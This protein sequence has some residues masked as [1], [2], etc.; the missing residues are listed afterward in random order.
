MHPQLYSFS[1]LPV[2]PHCSCCARDADFQA[3]VFSHIGDGKRLMLMI[4][5]AFR[6]YSLVLAT[7]DAAEAHDAGPAD[8]VFKCIGRRWEALMMQLMLM[9]LPFRPG[10]LALGQQE[11]ELMLMML[12]FRRLGTHA[13]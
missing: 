2:G 3:D 8:G 9:M 10:I 11:M 7:G 4:L 12:A 5:A 1:I 6:W 13:R